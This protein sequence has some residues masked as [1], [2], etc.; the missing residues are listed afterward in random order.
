M[1]K[2][3]GLSVLVIALAMLLSFGATFDKA[4]ADSILFP[5]VI[6]STAIST[7]VS[8]VNTADINPLVPPFLGI[9]QL[10]WSYFYK[11]D[12]AGGVDNSQ[13][14]SCQ[15]LDFKMETSLR[16]IVSVDC[17]GNV[18]GGLPMWGDTNNPL[19]A[20]VTAALTAPGDRRAFLIVDNNTP[21]LSLPTQLM[22]P[23]GTLYGEAMVVELAT[24]AAW[25]YVAFNSGGPFGDDTPWNPFIPPFPA[26]QNG[27]VS[28]S[29]VLDTHGEV[30]G[31]WN[32][33]AF[34]VPPAV[35][36]VPVAMELAPVTLMPPSDVI[37][38]FF[39]TPTDSLL[40]AIG[41]GN[42]PSQVANLGMR[43]G[44]MNARIG[45]CAIPQICDNAGLFGPV[46][47]ALPVAP[48]VCASVSG[49]C[50][51]GQCNL[52]GITLNDELPLSSTRL[53]NIVCTSADDISA[54]LDAG[55]Y[56]TWMSNG[57]QAWTYMNVELGNMVPNA[58]YQYTPNMMIG[59]LEW[60]DGGTTI[61]GTP[62]AGTFNNFVQPRNNK[63][64]FLTGPNSVPFGINNL[65]NLPQ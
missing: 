13:T 60:I 11:D 24:G 50:L 5:W 17:A 49:V 42:L 58:L 10:H 40:A 38:R 6:K 31:D 7:I 22:N 53:K 14:A 12:G 8:V 19:S 57:G 61:D 9:P 3:M 35:I 45:V 52:P 54:M 65:I 59:K 64:N 30:I 46:C 33:Y 25:G 27:W 23:D 18:N 37:T 2:K 1:R 29:N 56:A 20:G 34:A 48:F 32:A 43:N 47:A 28:F 16:D 26:G 63:D 44:N 41:L 4:N 21:L 15:D 55:T 62:V 36:T 51:T 39:L